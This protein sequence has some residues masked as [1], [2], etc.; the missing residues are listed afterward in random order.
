[1]MLCPK[2]NKEYSDEISVCSE[3]N[4]QLVKAED[5][6]IIGYIQDK[7]SSDFAIESLKTSE[8]PAVSI[9]NSGFFGNIGLPLNSIFGPKEALFE[10]SVPLS[11]K[12]EAIEILGITIG[13][14][15]KPVNRIDKKE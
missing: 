6:V 9:S 7:L 3:C 14:S 1:M 10:I 11:C 8:I 2:C 4:T 5:W 15:W 13:E 12:D